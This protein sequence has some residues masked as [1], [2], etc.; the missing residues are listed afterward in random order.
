MELTDYKDGLYNYVHDHGG[1]LLLL[2]DAV[3]GHAVVA[4][5]AVVVVVV[6]VVVAAVVVVVSQ[7]P[8]AVVRRHHHRVSPDHVNV[9]SEVVAFDG[10]EEGSVVRDHDGHVDG[11]QEDGDVP[12]GLVDAVVAQNP[13]GKRQLLLSVGSVYNVHNRA[14][15]DRREIST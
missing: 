1:L 2:G 12:A 11:G 4:V 15:E 10:L 8:P 9:A 7:V 3:L 13:S 5:A 6:S 14:L